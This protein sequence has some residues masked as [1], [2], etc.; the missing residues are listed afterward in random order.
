MKNSDDTSWDRTS[1]L[2]GI[3]TWEMQCTCEVPSGSRMVVLRK[4]M[5]SIP[6]AGLLVNY[7]KHFHELYDVH[8]P[9]A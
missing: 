2:C 9:M 1:E 8:N 5:E 7:Y 3:S 6:E 4:Q